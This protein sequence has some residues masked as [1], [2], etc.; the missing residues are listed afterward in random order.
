MVMQEIIQ[1]EIRPVI[2]AVGAEGLGEE[3]LGMKID[4]ETVK[5]LEVLEK[6]YGLNI[7]GEG[8][9]YEFYNLFYVFVCK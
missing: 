6:K 1:R 3:F 9:E 7:T 2:V 4:E 8:G 5:K